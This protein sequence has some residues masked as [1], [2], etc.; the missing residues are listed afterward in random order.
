M[1][2][3]KGK[4]KPEVVKGDKKA[5]VRFD[6]HY[7]RL[8]TRTQDSGTGDQGGDKWRAR[9]FQSKNDESQSQ[10]Q[11]LGVQRG[12]LARVTGRLLTRHRGRQDAGLVLSRRGVGEEA[13]SSQSR[14]C[15]E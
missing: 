8:E 9:L 1:E 5:C 4:V 3:G 15:V 11:S 6:D 13:G 12:L 14:R 2:R 7:Q 10:P